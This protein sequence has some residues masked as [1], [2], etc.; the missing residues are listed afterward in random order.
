MSGNT[1]K[2]S[3]AHIGHVSVKC[4]THL[5]TVNELGYVKRDFVRGWHSGGYI[6]P[7]CGSQQRPE[8]NKPG[9]KLERAP[10]EITSDKA[11]W[12]CCFLHAG[13]RRRRN[14][15]TVRCVRVS[16][17]NQFPL[18][19]L[20]IDSSKLTNSFSKLEDFF[21]QC[22]HWLFFEM[23][24]RT[25]YGNMASVSFCLINKNIQFSIK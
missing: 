14:A 9:D 11:S 23:H 5:L 7:G 8:V 10:Q 4:Q 12:N 6:T 1:K 25:L 22:C 21:F 15:M 19:N 3:S 18:N 2:H 13:R 24:R 17:A 20:H 16:S